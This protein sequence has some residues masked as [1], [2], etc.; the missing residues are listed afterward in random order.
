MFGC[1]GFRRIEFFKNMWSEVGYLQ[2]FV[3]RLRQSEMSSFSD[4]DADPLKVISGR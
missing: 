3:P 2:N 1:A 4:V